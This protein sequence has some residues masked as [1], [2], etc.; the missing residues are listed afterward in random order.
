[1]I[2]LPVTALLLLI[3][4]AMWGKREKRRRGIFITVS[5]LVWTLLFMVCY[6]CRAQDMWLLM[7]LGFPATV[8]TALACLVRKKAEPD[9]QNDINMHAEE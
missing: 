3:F 8:V 1:M 4:H 7:V 6:I 5:F 9:G 2:A